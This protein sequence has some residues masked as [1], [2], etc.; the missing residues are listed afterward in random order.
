V[1]FLEVVS[2]RV[3]CA[4]AVRSGEEEVLLDKAGTIMETAQW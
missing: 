2:R 1:R 3:D 4:R